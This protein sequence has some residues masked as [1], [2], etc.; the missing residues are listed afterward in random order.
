MTIVYEMSSRVPKFIDQSHLDT[1][2]AWTAYWSPILKTLTHQCLNPC[3]EI[4]QQAFG[5]LQRTLLSN[6]LASQ[7]HKEWTAIF[8]EVLFPLNTQLLKPEVFQ[9]DPLGMSETRVRAATLLCKVYLHYLVLLAEWEGMLDL[10]L[11]IITIMDRLI[12]SGQGD[13]LVSLFLPLIP[14]YQE[15][16]GVQEEAVSEN[17]KNVLLVMSN[18]G[19]LA[20]PEEKP[21]NE[22]IWNETWKRINRFLP[23]FY[24]ELFPEEA[25]KPKVESKPEEE[26]P[27]QEEPAQEVKTE[28]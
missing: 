24:A 26:K 14:S 8:S 3:R 21:E 25:R 27:S 20:P 15:L 18:A 10:W 11:K 7:D 1:N 6:D 19:F 23:N 17:L 4:R 13:N 28:A 22:Q 5:S 2:E 9:S 12:N 16:T